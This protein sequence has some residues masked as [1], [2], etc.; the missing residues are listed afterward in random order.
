MY[1]IK[2]DRYLS[3]SV[4][5]LKVNRHMKTAKVLHHPFTFKLF[6]QLQ[7]FIAGILPNARKRPYGSPH[8]PTPMPRS[9]TNRHHNRCRVNRHHNRCR[10]ILTGNELLRFVLRRS[11]ANCLSG[12]RSVIIKGTARLRPLVF[13][14]RGRHVPVT[15]TVTVTDIRRRLVR[16]HSIDIVNSHR[17]LEAI[18]RPRDT[19][20]TTR[21]NRTEHH[22][23]ERRRVITKNTDRGA[24][25]LIVTGCLRPPR[26]RPSFSVS[27]PSEESTWKASIPTFLEN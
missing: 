26:C 8:Q 24:I 10:V 23:K 15:E 4:R 19:G 17:P 25:R 1:K 14:H 27:S 5:V 2:M 9:Q 18:I 12:R 16:P 13:L 6:Q 7:S 11:R 20:T 22:P 3:Y 21:K